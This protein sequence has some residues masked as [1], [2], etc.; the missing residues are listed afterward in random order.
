MR[1]QTV[2]AIFLLSLVLL[3]QA[4]AAN[5]QTYSPS[6]ITATNS[7]AWYATDGTLWISDGN[8]IKK[9][10][11]GG[12][13]LSAPIQTWTT[14]DCL[15]CVFVDSRGYIYVS[16]YGAN[17]AGS[18]KGLWRSTDGVNFTKV[19]DLS[20]LPNAIGIW[21]IDETPTG[22]IYAGTYSKEHKIY[23]S[24]DGQTWH[25]EYYTPDGNHIHNL[26]VDPTNNYVYATIGDTGAALLAKYD[27]SSWTELS[28]QIGGKALPQLTGVI[29]APTT[30]TSTKIY[31]TDSSGATPFRIYTTTDDLNYNLVYE[32]S[33]AD[34]NYS[35][36]NYWVRRDPATGYLYAG[37]TKVDDTAGMYGN[38][39]YSQDNGAHWSILT[40]FTDGVTGGDGPQFGSNIH[41]SN[42]I[43]SHQAAGKRLAGYSISLASRNLIGTV[44]DANT[45]LPIANATVT[46]GG[47]STTTAGDGTYSLTLPAGTY[48]VTASAAGHVS[49]NQN[50]TI[51]NNQTTQVNFALQPSV[52]PGS[53][54]GHVYDANTFAVISGAT[55][56]LTPGGPSTQTDASG[57]Y[58]FN[59][60]APGNYTVTASATGY[61]PG[62]KT[63][64]VNSG[65]TS[66]VDFALQPSVSPGS[67]VGQVTNS[68]TAA[69]ISG[70]T[71]TLAPGGQTTQ[72]NASGSYAF[73]N[74]SPGSYTVTA[75]ATGYQPGSKTT[76]VNSGATS[77]VDLALTPL[78]SP[79]SIV[80][81]VTN[82][83]TSAA[84]SGATVTLT[85]GQSTQTDATGYYAFNNLAPGSYT[86][87]ASATGYQPG[88]KTTTVNSGGT[89]TVD[90]A[91]QPSSVSIVGYL[92]NS[93]AA[94]SGA[95]VTLNPGGQSTQTDANGYYAFTNLAPGNYTVTASWALSV[96]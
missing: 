55:V 74:L 62:S 89:S 7:A 37:N 29:I 58:A 12:I 33:A 27:G 88:I 96:H 65:A 5:A 35:D 72:T 83:S 20:N 50:A 24:T 85:G 38:I 42:L 3:F 15:E 9:S 18:D 95:T 39:I 56:T 10:S 76:T 54:V 51:T 31:F 75:S 22:K 26:H 78:V 43:V 46:A 49:Q 91:L 40:Q 57:A 44:T 28:P 1:Y 14:A 77:T 25:L 93:G 41:N 45:S 79:G 19:L 94:I 8:S 21:G 71:V 16:P 63:T 59:N 87:T 66:T 11:D 34:G 67:I 52:S 13:T 73:T 47:Q 80:G 32:S 69:A 86:V 48:V 6:P 30:P 4:L 82:S 60:L 68:S 23:S 17:L 84:I 2:L 90:F 70:A 64:T 61:Q 92:T 36:D 81:H 53:I